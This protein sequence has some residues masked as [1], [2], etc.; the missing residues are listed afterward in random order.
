M[1]EIMKTNKRRK[2]YMI[3]LTMLRFPMDEDDKRG[4][5]VEI[6]RIEGRFPVCEHYYHPTNS[7]LHRVIS[8]L[9]RS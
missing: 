3:E 5:T 6:R 7:S 9:E 2:I 4:N 8:L 1:S